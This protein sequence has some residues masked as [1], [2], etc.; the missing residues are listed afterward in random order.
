MNMS[1]VGDSTSGLTT[2]VRLLVAA[3][4]RAWARAE[5]EGPSSVWH[6]HGLGALVAA[7][8]GAALAGRDVQD[9]EFD[10]SGWS[11]A[12]TD[13]VALVQAAEAAC[14]AV[15]FDQWPPGASAFV[16]AVADLVREW[17]P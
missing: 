14:R 4:D 9:L 11:L 13:P 5:V 15:P 12:E 3:A 16:V 7:S 8:Q 17:T 2:V 6:V 1:T 10:I